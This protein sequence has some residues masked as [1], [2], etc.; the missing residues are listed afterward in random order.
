MGYNF[1][2]NGGKLV[3]LGLAA[4]D[5]VTVPPSAPF[6]EGRADQL[7][8]RRPQM[9][10]A[11]R[12]A[13]ARACGPEVDPFLEQPASGSCA[14]WGYKG[15]PFSLMGD[16]PDKPCS[17]RAPCQ[18][19]WGATGPHQSSTPSFHPDLS[20]PPFSYRCWSQINILH[21]KFP[22]SRELYLQHSKNQK[23]MLLYF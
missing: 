20:S 3:P 6:Q 5:K 21:P 1:I 14:R 8:G 22:A 10:P 13:S 9:S 11:S 17:H 16:S 4:H 23:P 7:W 12:W 19:D 2:W 18:V 15:P